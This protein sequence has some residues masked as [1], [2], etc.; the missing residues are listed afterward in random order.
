MYDMFMSEAMPEFLSHGSLFICLYC[1]KLKINS[2]SIFFL[3]PL[4][5]VDLNNTSLSSDVCI[6]AAD[7]LCVSLDSA[8]CFIKFSQLYQQAPSG[9]VLN[10]FLTVKLSLIAATHS[11]NAAG[12]SELAFKVGCL[13]NGQQVDYDVLGLEGEI[14]W[15]ANQLSNP[16]KVL[17]G[18]FSG[19]V[20]DCKSRLC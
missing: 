15:P 2:I 7:C 5:S 1:C 18:C 14:N 13:S 6:A 16:S 8:P 4:C 12:C 11:T 19:L 17:R 9:F 20:L 3:S 10:Q